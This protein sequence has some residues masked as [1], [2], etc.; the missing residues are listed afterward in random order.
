MHWATFERLLATYDTYVD[1]ALAAHADWVR[2]VE[3]RVGT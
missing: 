1:A 3:R 2:R